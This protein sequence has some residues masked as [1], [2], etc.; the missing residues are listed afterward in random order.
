[1]LAAI[2]A[3]VGRFE[4][5]DPLDPSTSFGPLASLRQRDVV[6][7][8]IGSGVDEGADLVLDGRGARSP[9]YYVGPTIFTNV[10][11]HHRIARE[12]IF[13]PVLSVFRYSEID[14]AVELANDSPYGLAATVWTRDLP[15]AHQLAGRIQAGNIRIASSP[16]Q[17]EG[18]GLSHSGEPVGQSGFGV[19]GGIKGMESYTRLQSVEFAIAR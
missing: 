8:Y 1:M 18:A 10:A 6:E 13:G 19:E 14:E 12:E 16:E 11:A 3:A 2:V 5:G 9:G 17:V 15:L 4:P 7:S